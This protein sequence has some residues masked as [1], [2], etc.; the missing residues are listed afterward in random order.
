[1]NSEF[2]SSTVELM[3]A[4]ERNWD[5]R[6]PIHAA[7]QFYGA[8]GS[9]PAQWWFAAFEWDDLGPL[10][11]RDLVHLQCH[12]GTE[13]IEF[14]RRGAR[15]VGLDFSGQAVEHA[16]RIAEHHGVDVDY[17]KSD[18]YDAVTALGA[19]RFDIVYIGKGSLCYLPDLDRWAAVVAELLAPGGLAYVVE[20]HPVLTSMGPKP[21]PDRQELVL[22][23]DYLQGRGP[24]EHDS[25]HTYTDGP[26]LPADAAPVYEWAHGLG[27]VVTALVGAGLTITRLRETEQ[28]P[29][30]RFDRM[31][32]DDDTGW[33]QLPPTDAR[34]PLLYALAATK[35]NGTG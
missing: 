28:L 12:L 2:D 4:N 35:T 29:W 1:M 17:V 30:P 8:D 33:W 11:D 27:E 22:R 7:S 5:A 16:R 34:I 14:A 20:F 26:A 31:V 24:V 21:E 9:T 32:R 13:T 6:T 10:A 25:T 3:R 15:T 23:N 18:V 19:G